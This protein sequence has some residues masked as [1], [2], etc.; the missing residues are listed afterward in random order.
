MGIAK[1]SIQARDKIR[2][3]S[4]MAAGRPFDKTES[5]ILTRYCTANKKVITEKAAKN[6]AKCS[7]KIYFAK[8]NLRI[9]VLGSKFSLKSLQFEEFESD[10]T[11]K[12]PIKEP[13]CK[14]YLN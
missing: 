2:I 1:A 4:K 5:R 7:F 10:M 6:G 12:T 14:P 11:I 13:A 3:S 9:T 8:I